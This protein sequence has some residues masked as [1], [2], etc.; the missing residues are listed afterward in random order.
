MKRFGFLFLFVIFCLSSCK[1]SQYKQNVLKTCIYSDPQTLDTRKA[2]D[3]IS[4]QVLYML[5]RGLMHYSSDGTLVCSLAES[6]EISEDKTK[7]VF[8]LKD[9]Y[10]SDGK[11]ITAHDFESSWKK[12]LDPSFPSLY[13]ELLYPIKNAEKAKNKEIGIDLVPIKA[14]DEKTLF[15]EL[16]NPNPYFLFL[17]SFYLYFPMPG[18][19]MSNSLEFKADS[20]T[21]SGP[22]SLKK[23]KNNDRLILEKNP[24]FYDKD[25]IKLDSIQIKIVSNENTAFQMYENNDID[26]LSSFLSPLNVD[27]LGKIQQRD[28]VK[29][30]PIAGFGFISFNTNAFPFNNAN[31]RKAFSLAIDRKLIVDNITQLNEKTAGRVIPPVLVN[32]ENKNLIENNNVDSAKVFFKKALE[33]LNMSKGQLHLTFTLGSYTVHRKE[34]EALKQMWEKAFDIPIKLNLLEDKVYLS[35]LKNHDYQF[36][37]GRLI[38]RYNDPINIFERY[39]YKD[40]IKNYSCWENKEFIDLLNS[41]KKE[42]DPVKR[43]QIIE[44]AEKILIDAMPITPLYFYNY[45]MLKKKYVK[46]IYATIVGDLLFDETSVTR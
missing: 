16:E 12:I 19:I 17:T 30:T 5:Y 15:V 20:L 42:F 41:A 4:S 39:K 25:K 2:G 24:Y 3:Y 23:W 44:Q 13:A 35:K 28:D 37:L 34:A 6:Y 21:F 7:Y 22:F 26:F 31:L 45:T 36:A 27:T 33:E 38:V 40:S 1:K 43:T 11:P 9:V 18:H 29:I 46:G 32:S 8:H 14:L 10:W